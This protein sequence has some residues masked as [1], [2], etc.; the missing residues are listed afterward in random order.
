M[1]IL[2][3]GLGDVPP[4]YHFAS[5]HC[6]NYI[7]RYMDGHEIITFGYN[8]GVDIQIKPE[9]D[10]AVVTEKLPHGW[11]PDCC[12]LWEVDWN[13]LPRGIENAPFPAVAIPFDWDYDIP[14]AKAC[15]ELTDFTIASGATE[16]NALRALTAEGKI[17]KCY[18]G[19]IMQKYF[20]QS[21][22]KIKDRKIDIFYTMG[23]SHL[24]HLDR[25][26]WV[27]R[28]TH[29]S[30]TY[31]IKIGAHQ[32]NY[33]DYIEALRDSK[34]V[35]SHQR[36]GSMSGR[37]LDAGAQGTVTIETGVEAE[38]H[39]IPN[40]DFV[41]VNEENFN[42][43]ITKYLTN[44][45]LLQKLSDNVYLK[46]TREFESRIRFIKLLEFL[47]DLFKSRKLRKKT[48][49]TGSAKRHLQRGEIY[50]YS[51]FRTHNYFIAKSGSKL[52]DLSI[53]EFKKAVSVDPSPNAMIS[54]AVALMAYGF[55]NHRKED[56]QDVLQGV[57]TILEQVIASHP[58]DA[59]AY[60]NLGLLNTRIANYGK[61]LDFFTVAL[62]LLNDTECRIDPWCLHNRDLEVF[63]QL[64]RKHLNENLLLLCSGKKDIA[65]GKIRNL[66]KA[67]ILYLIATIE[68][69]H[70]RVDKVLEALLEAQKLFPASGAIT[71]NAA[72][73]LFQLGYYEE[74][75]KMYEKATS[76]LPMH[77][78]ARME[79]L[80]LLYACRMD[81]KADTE[82]EKVVNIIKSVEIWSKS[83]TD[84]FVKLKDD[85]AKPYNS[86]NICKEK[87]LN[88]SVKLLYGYLQKNPNN[89]TIIM[90]IAE[91]W[92]ELG[93]LDK[94]LEI[95]ENY[96]SND[97]G[98]MKDDKVRS[99]MK[100]IYERYQLAGEQ[101]NKA[102]LLKLANLKK[103]LCP[104]QNGT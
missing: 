29:L 92:A 89:A 7:E 13:L 8:K 104:V 100:D 40:E 67:V 9:D 60:F 4:R 27:I 36:F 31:R 65:L 75:I 18:P 96:M 51:F 52:L 97:T 33:D 71:V 3:L 63:N 103:F 39:L 59:M 86:Y 44:E 57:T 25:V 54:L 68:E 35:F 77:I 38:N 95:L 16:Q 55:S 56:L 53:E 22:K 74:S 90:R 73:K 37:I 19:G 12:I 10:F 21:P 78:D 76:V 93:R 62:K 50:Y 94:A 61:A 24:E 101:Q 84:A 70:G 6:E 17:E 99:Q 43:Q 98:L 49:V 28:L 66:Y 26:K 34:L 81:S 64:V 5:T 23:E 91:I 83:K 30:D 88:S 46:V 80:M 41:P 82:V 48:N 2:V 15:I 47:Q 85:C 58:Q 20:A 69:E 72:K 87:L 79:Y 42:E 102:L 1:K 45:P 11:A 14:L 32:S